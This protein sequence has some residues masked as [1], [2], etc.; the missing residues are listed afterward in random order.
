M[1]DA[2]KAGLN[3]GDARILVSR[4]EV[5]DAYARAGQLN[6]ALERYGTVRRQAKRLSLRT[7]E[8]MALFHRAILLSAV[9]SSHPVYRSST[10]AV[11]REIERTS[12]PEMAPFRNA[13]RLIDVKLMDDGPKRSAALQA[14]LASMEPVATT[15]PMLLYSP[16]INL[17]RND[18]G[19]ASGDEKTPWVDIGF[20]VAADGTVKDVETLGASKNVV[21]HWTAMITQAIEQRRYMP[22]SLSDGAAGLHRVERY[23]FVSDLVVETGSRARYRLPNGRIVATD[24]TPDIKAEAPKG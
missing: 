14:A 9:G 17:E 21:P 15:R 2:L 23:S 6:D 3:K 4:L 24:L 5:G 11:V 18:F 13:V 8:G 12:D 10:R 16:T 22:I 20:V 19:I 1:I 7:V